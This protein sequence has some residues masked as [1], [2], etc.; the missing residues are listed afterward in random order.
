VTKF[1]NRST[2]ADDM[3]VFGKVADWSDRESFQEDLNTLV[4]WANR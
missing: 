4:N 3:K 2:F 1:E